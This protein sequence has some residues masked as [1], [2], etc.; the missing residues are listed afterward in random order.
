[1]LTV[2]QNGVTEVT[3]KGQMQTCR[4]HVCYIRPEV[5]L[6]TLPVVSDPDHTRSA[7]NAPASSPCAR[8]AIRITVGTRFAL[9]RAR[10]LMV[11]TRCKEHSIPRWRYG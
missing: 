2:K 9:E 4:D 5:S 1:M 6:H 11:R 8:T 3:K 10:L 7:A